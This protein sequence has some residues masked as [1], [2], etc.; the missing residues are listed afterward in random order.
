MCAVLQTVQAGFYFTPGWAYAPRW[1]PHISH[2]SQ[3]ETV[4][5]AMGSCVELRL[6]HYIPD[7]LGLGIS[8]CNDMAWDDSYMHRSRTGSVKITIPEVAGS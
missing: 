6:S 3:T 1:P 2:A 4:N 5:S 7:H 8:T